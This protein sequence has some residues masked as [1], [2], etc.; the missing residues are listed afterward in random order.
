MYTR[1]YRIVFGGQ[2]EAVEAHRLE[3]VEALHFFE[4]RVAVAQCVIVPMPYM[5]LCAA[6]IRKH[7]QHV[8]LARGVVFV[9]F[10]QSGL[11][12]D[13]VPFFFYAYIVHKLYNNT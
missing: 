4:A 13:F 5:E 11:L 2:S 12:P 10:V 3:Y 9:E 7:F 8:M 6:R 1:L